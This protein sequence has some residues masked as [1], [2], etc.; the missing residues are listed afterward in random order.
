MIRDLH[1]TFFLGSRHLT[2]FHTAD[3]RCHGK[4]DQYERRFGGQQSSMLTINPKKGGNIHVAT[5]ASESLL[6]TAPEKRH[7]P[8]LF[9][10]CSRNEDGNSVCS[11]AVNA[12]HTPH[13][14][15]IP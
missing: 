10:T 8:S 2:A 14:I 11:T 12:A 3:R 7:W 6:C 15:D 9:L 4:S 1:G 13:N 5:N